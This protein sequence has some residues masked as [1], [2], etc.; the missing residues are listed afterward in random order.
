MIKTT[1]EGWQTHLTSNSDMSILYLYG[2]NSR[3][4]IQS[5]SKSYQ[6]SI[7]MGGKRRVIIGIILVTSGFQW[8]DQLLAYGWIKTTQ[9]QMT[10]SMREF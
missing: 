9:E 6:N 7:C 5:P 2:Q 3:Y 4:N 1:S 8:L 10:L